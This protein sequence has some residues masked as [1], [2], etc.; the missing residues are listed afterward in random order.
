MSK[1]NFET[2]IADLYEANCDIEELEQALYRLIRENDCS[3]V[4]A[5]S[6]VQQIIARATDAGSSL[7]RA[8]T[9]GFSGDKNDA[10]S[11]YIF[12]IHKGE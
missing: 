4:V 1:P 5:Y 7:E 2:E 6:L 9:Y 12:K 8:Q 10:I 11:Y 3:E